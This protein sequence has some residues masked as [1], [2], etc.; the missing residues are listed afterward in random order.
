MDGS[1]IIDIKPYSKSYLMVDKLKMPDWMEQIHRELKPIEGEP[2]ECPTNYGNRRLEAL[3]RLHGHVC[4]GLAIGYKAA[5]TGMDWLK[6]KRALDEE[7]V[8]IVETDACCCG[9]DTGVSSLAALLQ[10]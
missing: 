9:R 7:L 8:A 1:P 4:G 2:H 6:G 10:R 5:T 3:C